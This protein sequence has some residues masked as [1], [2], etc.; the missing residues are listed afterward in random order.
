MRYHK[1]HMSR[2]LILEISSDQEK[3]EMLVRKFREI[4]MPADYVNKLSRMLQDIE[5][6]KDTN[7]TVK[8][9]LLQHNNNDSS[10]LADMMHLKILNIGAWGKSR[11]TSVTLPRD[12]EEFTG[13]IEEVYKKMHCG[14]KLFWSSQMSTA[15]IVY[16]TKHGKYDFDVSA[17]QLSLL[18]VFN[19]RPHDKIA[20]G[21]LKLATQIGDVE[22]GRTI[23]SLVAYP[24]LREQVL[25]TDVKNPSPKSFSDS[26]LLWINHDFA[27]YKNDKPQ[28]RGKLNLVGR[29]NVMHDPQVE[30]ECEEVMQLRTFRLQE[31][32]VKIMKTR[33]KLTSAQLQT[34]LIQ[35][36]KQMFF[37]SR[38]LIKEQLEWLIENKF[39]ARDDSDMNTF[40][41][42]T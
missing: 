28:P 14:R 36:L 19:S 17:L 37:P 42:I 15:T 38:K 4:G 3:E 16:T 13:E 41:Y 27:L 7:A 33:R 6:N 39:I 8:S 30:L 18:N 9:Y 1:I 5:V 11:T 21:D 10:K 25:I 23:M 22:M 31:A 35:M 20:F 40:V 24:K 34:E 12:L 2:R 32:I 26:S 29:L